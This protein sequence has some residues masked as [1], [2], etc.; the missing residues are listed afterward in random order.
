MSASIVLYRHT[1]LEIKNLI[2]DLNSND[3]VS[4]IFLIDNNVSGSVD[5]SSIFNPKTIFIKPKSNVGYGA[6]Q[7]RGI[8]RDH[9]R[10]E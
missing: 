2:V 6:G 9:R 10:P 4:Q 8:W 7:A 5:Y 1:P 3:C